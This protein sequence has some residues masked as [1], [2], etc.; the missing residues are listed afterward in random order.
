MINLLKIE[1]LKVKNYRA[2]IVIG[3]FFIVGIFVTNYIVNLFFEKVIN[4]SEASKLINR[5][6]PYT[7]KYV[8]QTISYTSGFILLLPALLIIILLT[9]EFTFKTHRQNIIDGW[10]RMEFMHVKMLLALLFAIFSTVLVFIAGLIFGLSTKTDLE[11]V[12]IAHLGFFFLKA[13]SY[14][15]FAI[16][17]AIWIKKTG[18]AIGVYFIYM[19]AE[20]IIAQLL[21]VWSL[22]IKAKGSFDP[23]SMGNYLPMNASDGLLTFPDNPIKAL[24]QNSFPSNYPNLVFG[25]AIAYLILFYLLSRKKM[26]SSDL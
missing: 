6:N 12:G 20:N 16:L 21:D 13:L 25:I 4:E 14:N 10:S 26:I 22:K 1:W 8:W 19:G 24:T 2:F 11:F 23:G 18:F 15:M 7:F 3:I 5:F 9:N 17:V